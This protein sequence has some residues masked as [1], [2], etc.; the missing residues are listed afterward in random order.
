VAQELTT[1]ALNRRNV[2]HASLAADA[3]V[4]PQQ[5]S[6]WISNQHPDLP[7]LGHI[8]RMRNPDIAESVADQLRVLAAQWRA[9]DVQ[10]RAEGA[11][12]QPLIVRVLLCVARIGSL[13]A[14]ASE[15]ARQYAWVTDPQS[16]HGHKISSEEKESVIEIAEKTDNELTEA[17][18]DLRTLLHTLRQLPVEH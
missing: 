7:N 15:L 14:R 10:K 18:T 5:Y 3:G 13:T 11:K 4:S 2:K 9:D 17:Q 16:E 1:S 6:R 8:V 12:E